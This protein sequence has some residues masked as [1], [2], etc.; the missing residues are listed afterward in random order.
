[1]LIN[2]A[3]EGFNQLVTIFGYAFIAIS[4]GYIIG[5]LVGVARERRR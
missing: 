5:A 2:T 4:V 1:M 3:N